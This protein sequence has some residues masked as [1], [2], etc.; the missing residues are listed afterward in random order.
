MKFYLLLACSLLSA[1][2]V[3]QQ[4]ETPPP[5]K[6]EP[7]AVGYLPVG[8]LN[9]TDILKGPPALGSAEEAADFATVAEAQRTVS[10]ERWASA[11]LDDK[12]LLVRF[13]DTLGVPLN[14]ATLPRTVKL[15]NRALRDA[16]NVSSAGKSEF[17][18]ARPFQR[19]QVAR[20]CGHDPALPPEPVPKTLTSYPSGHTTYGWTTAL[21]LSDIVP[22]KTPA[23]FLRARDY[24]ESRYICGWH[25]P[26]DVEGGKRIA[27]ATV[28]RL[29][30]DPTFKR[31]L[32]CATAE[33]R[34]VTRGEKMPKSCQ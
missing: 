21:V 23:L 26:S 3:A 22:E 12:M 8:T 34:N 29:E 18:R 13:S 25:F 27:T 1:S 28:A 31:D 17:K 19:V 4:I 24:G 7:K 14:R 5:P 6:D 9:F 33:Y 2:A 11:E 32:A 20:L 30:Q 15:L 16:Y 10:P